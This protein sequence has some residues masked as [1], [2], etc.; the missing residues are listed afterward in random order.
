M[1][2]SDRT[3]CPYVLRRH[4][5]LCR[6]VAGPMARSPSLSQSS[7]VPL[8]LVMLSTTSTSSDTTCTCHSLLPRGTHYSR[9]PGIGRGNATDGRSRQVFSHRQQV[10]Q[11]SPGLVASF[12]AQGR[13]LLA[14]GSTT[15]NATTNVSCGGCL[16]AGSTC[17][18]K[19]LP[20]SIPA[21]ASRCPAHLP[22]Y[23]YAPATP[24]PS[25]LQRTCS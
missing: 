17:K 25:L 12:V 9:E 8:V 20:L 24:R 3:T 22:M 5:G 6:A 23:K 14:R 4:C 11:A 16:S 15:D 10:Q 21:A 18:G 13:G 1:R 2:A 19:G 7:W